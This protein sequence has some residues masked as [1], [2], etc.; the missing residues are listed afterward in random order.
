M[1]QKAHYSTYQNILSLKKDKD[2]LSLKNI[3]SLKDTI[4]D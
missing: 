2:I 4:E 1:D 3:L